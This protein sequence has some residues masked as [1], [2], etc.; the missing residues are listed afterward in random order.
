LE[1]K[2]LIQKVKESN[3]IIEVASLYISLQKSGKS[4]RALCPF[5]QE[6]TPS[7]HMYPGTQ[8]YY[9]FGCG[10]TG[11]V[12]R[13]VQEIEQITFPDA[14]RKLADRVHI[15]IEIDKKENPALFR[16]TQFYLDF[17]RYYHQ[18][19][20]KTPAALDYITHQRKLNITTIEEFSIG[21]IPKG[22][23]Y[24]EELPFSKELANQYKLIDHDGRMRFHNRVIF[25]IQDSYGRILGIAGRSL[26][27]GKGVQKYMNSSENQFFKKSWLLFLEH[28][29]K[30]HIKETG[31]AI[32]V[33]GYLDA[34]SLYAHG[35]KNTI[36]IMGTSLSAVQIRKIRSYTD[37]ILLLFD[38]DEAGYKAL[39]KS[40]FQIPPNVSVAV[41]QLPD[42]KDPDEFIREH[43]QKAFK[44]QLSQAKRIEEIVANMTAK[45]Y[46]LSKAEGK[47]GFLARIQPAA[48]HLN[49]PDSLGRF[50]SFLQQI[51][52]IVD[53]PLDRIRLW[54]DPSAGE[55]PNQKPESEPI[56]LSEIENKNDAELQIL[57][58]FLLHPS[59]RAEVKKGL[60]SLEPFLSEG[61]TRFFR[62]IGSHFD[63]EDSAQ[64]L[65]DYFPTHFVDRF[66]S[67]QRNTDVSLFPEKALKDCFGQLL[68][69]KINHEIQVIDQELR[70][71]T[72]STRNK[73]LLEQRMA[74]SKKKSHI[75]MKGGFPIE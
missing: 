53:L 21:Y 15:P 48:H 35:F 55:K 24:S 56:R 74:L 28:K 44:D 10:A 52:S 30:G 25:P 45:Q 61:M 17:F 29:A 50:D 54:A 70:S 19:L 65:R 34:L 23:A 62:A 47:D 16:Q 49:H 6:K 36:A 51:A 46:D 39:L 20:K 32:V 41:A 33:E 14:L 22:S 43:G 40:L 9:C 26:E 5:H 73:D 60:L 64:H 1:R 38:N 11:D 72:D 57:I 8:S 68:M 66:F 63:P 75:R 31:F 4:H 12:I 27:S 18:I 3:D 58:V 42:S 2:E 37:K 13:F 7:F 67:K 59:M 69:R 71:D